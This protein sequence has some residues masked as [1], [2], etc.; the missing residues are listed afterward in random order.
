MPQIVVE[1]SE[2]GSPKTQAQS[3]QTSSTGLDRKSASQGKLVAQ[4]QRDE[5]S[6]LYCQ[7]VRVD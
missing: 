1:S 7:W 4:W 5:N 2:I 3:A 6:K